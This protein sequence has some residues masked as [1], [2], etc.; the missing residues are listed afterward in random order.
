MMH[1]GHFLRPRFIG[2]GRS[3]TQIPFIHNPQNKESARHV[4][5]NRYYSTVHHLQVKNL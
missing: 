4:T 1:K 2:P 5:S 3:R